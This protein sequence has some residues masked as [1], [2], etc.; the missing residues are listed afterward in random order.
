MKREEDTSTQEQINREWKDFRSQDGSR[1][2][3][4]RSWPLAHT[5]G[6]RGR[7]HRGG[8]PRPG[9][10]PGRD[11][12]LV[13]PGG[14]RP[15]GHGHRGRETGPQR[16]S[17]RPAGPPGS[18]IGDGA[19]G[20]ENGDGARGTD[21]AADALDPGSPGGTGHGRGDGGDGCGGG[22]DWRTGRDRTHLRTG[23]HHLRPPEG[24]GGE[25]ALRGPH[26]H[27]RDAGRCSRRASHGPAGWGCT[28]VKQVGIE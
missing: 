11:G 17:G 13:H 16:Q 20:S 9:E 23:L 25:R 2:L 10:R 6:W 28:P 4:R 21:P 18:G 8:A 24:Q 5:T 14:G 3:R 26:P 27:H 7:P 15:A 12:P 19:P 22:C 1:R